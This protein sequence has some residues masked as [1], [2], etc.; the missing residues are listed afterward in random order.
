M[1]TPHHRQGTS[2]MLSFPP[3]FDCARCCRVC[4]DQAGYLWDMRT[5]LPCRTMHRITVRAEVAHTRS[6]TVLQDYT[7][8][9]PLAEASHFRY[10]WQKD[11]PPRTEH[12][13]LCHFH[14]DCAALDVDHRASLP[15][16]GWLWVLDRLDSVLA[17]AYRDLCLNLRCTPHLSPFTHPGLPCP[18]Q[19]DMLAQ[20][21]QGWREL[22]C[23]RQWVRICF[24]AWA[25]LRASADSHGHMLRV[26]SDITEPA[27]ESRI[28]I[29]LILCA[30]PAGLT[31]QSNQAPAF[32]TPAQGSGINTTPPNH[33]VSRNVGARRLQDNPTANPNVVTSS[34]R[35]WQEQVAREVDDAVAT[36]SPPEQV[37]VLAQ[38]HATLRTGPPTGLHSPTLSHSY[39][40]RRPY[41]LSEMTC[42]LNGCS[43]PTV[44]DRPLTAPPR[45]GSSQ[46]ED[47]GGMLP[48][49]LYPSEASMY[50]CLQGLLAVIPY[51]RERHVQ[52]LILLAGKMHLYL[53]TYPLKSSCMCSAINP[54]LLQVSAP[55]WPSACTQISLTLEV[56]TWP[57][58]PVLRQELWHA[59]AG[60]SDCSCR[61][62]CLHKRLAIP[63]I[64]HGTAPALLQ[65]PTVHFG[66]ILQHPCSTWSICCAEVRCTSWQ[67]TKQRISYQ[68]LPR[69]TQMILRHLMISREY[70]TLGDGGTYC[71]KLAKP[72]LK[73]ARYQCRWRPAMGAAPGRLMWRRRMA[74]LSP[75]VPHVQGP[76]GDWL[77]MRK[78]DLAKQQGRTLLTDQE[79]P[80]LG[81][82]HRLQWTRIGE[83]SQ[84]PT[85]L[86]QRYVHERL[87][88]MTLQLWLRKVP[89]DHRHHGPDLWERLGYA[90]T[91]WP[92]C[93]G[94]C[95]TRSGGTSAAD[96]IP[97]TSNKTYGWGWD[98][99]S[100]HFEH[101]ETA[102]KGTEPHCPTTLQATC[103]S[104]A[105]AAH[106][107]RSFT[108][109]VH[110]LAHQ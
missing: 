51:Q 81:D 109:V 84:D 105:I 108:G 15:E 22:T 88:V 29:T 56:F 61:T 19:V 32:G 107:H 72:P 16:L 36:M 67:G 43:V 38:L 87:L 50:E 45:P 46:T 11:R 1:R 55:C 3:T 89:P 60:R 66:S 82:H 12:T 8:L 106:G 76:S 103:P 92:T 101:G 31:D 33:M 24:L 83:A 74:P 58:T 44:P 21:F 78:L 10:C 69:Q 9:W 53:G 7:T 91:G 62:A 47:F 23:L 79:V 86:P 75:P 80:S 26:A 77:G 85:G 28:R 14:S 30:S 64:N 2:A 17:P 100:R 71:E 98:E 63:A 4:L 99:T 73:A 65:R 34:M 59:E 20:V 102:S 52:L 35:T 18:P 54:W 68:S 97:S 42:R 110:A 40:C 57:A 94:A 27:P 37:S 13:F 93:T 90:S 96:S 5:P 95:T 6:K 48:D 25:S 70:L 49:M 41:T 39:A 104:S